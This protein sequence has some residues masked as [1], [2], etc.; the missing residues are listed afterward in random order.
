MSK[1]TKIVYTIKRARVGKP[2]E[3]PNLD[4]MLEALREILANREKSGFL[5][6]IWL[7][8]EANLEEE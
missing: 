1:T 6:K 4:A 8:V 5:G 3:Y 7:T 2:I